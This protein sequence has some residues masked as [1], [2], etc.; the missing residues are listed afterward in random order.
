M[1]TICSLLNV[2]QVVMHRYVRTYKYNQSN[3]ICLY[4]ALNTW[5]HKSQHYCKLKL[6]S[7][8][9]LAIA[10][11][12]QVHINFIHYLAVQAHMASW[13][14]PNYTKICYYFSHT[15]YWFW[16]N[17]LVFKRLAISDSWTNSQCITT[18]KWF[19]MQLPCNPLLDC[20]IINTQTSWHYHSTSQ[21]GKLNN[22][23]ITYACNYLWQELYNP[24]LT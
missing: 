20:L 13:L 9:Y 3:I 1:C 6:S 11:H 5:Y 21:T 15:S 24:R 10:I 16:S 4:N 23:M 8:S 18:L 7:F 2:F 22:N 17:I 19:I 12:L 14:P